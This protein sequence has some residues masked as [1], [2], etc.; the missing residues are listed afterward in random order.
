[1]TLTL[2]NITI[3]FLCAPAG[4]EE[5]ELLRTWTAIAEA[6]GDRRLVSI[7]DD[8][9]QCLHGLDR[10]DRI[11]VDVSLADA[12]VDDFDGLVLP[13]GARNADGLRAHP[14]AAAF[15]RAFFQAAK[16]VVAIGHAPSV[17]IDAEVLAGRT[18]TSAASIATDIRN[19]GGAWVD[20]RVQVCTDGASMLMTSAGGDDLDAL[21]SVI[22][23][24]F[25]PSQPST[26][27][28]ATTA[29]RTFTRTPLPRAWP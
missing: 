7:T 16:P 14:A 20:H 18:V 26:T 25:D 1:M 12:G 15:T 27:L 10:A 22:A 24:F 9:I 6:G 21:C 2:D 5:D 28:I 13:G 17:L 11:T 23:G 29:D 3:A 19:A 8:T 4:V